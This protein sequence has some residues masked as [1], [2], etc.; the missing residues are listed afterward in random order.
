MSQCE[1]GSLHVDEDFAAV[2]FIPIDE[3]TCTEIVGTN[4]AIPRRRSC[5]TTRK[6]WRCSR[7]ELHASADGQ[8]A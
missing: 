7:R 4:F 3:T 6:I 2:E 8:G 5:A 1:P